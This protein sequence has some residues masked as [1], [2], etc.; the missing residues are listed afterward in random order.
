MLEAKHSGI[1]F[2]I[3]CSVTVWAFSKE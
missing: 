2:W 3:R 1:F